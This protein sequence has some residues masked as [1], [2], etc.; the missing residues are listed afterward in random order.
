MINMKPLKYPFTFE[1]WK[2]HKSTKPKLKL[3]KCLADEI[4]HGKQL[5]F[6]M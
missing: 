4:K 2:N 6:E 5:E 1:Q 3:I